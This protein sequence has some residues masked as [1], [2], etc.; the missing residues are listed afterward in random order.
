MRPQGNNANSRGNNQKATTE[1]R[2]FVI[3]PP[4][5]QSSNSVIKVV[6][7]FPDVFPEELSGL[8]P[9]SDIEFAIDLY[10]D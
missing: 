6:R 10:P 1:G 8:P 5:A 7:E 2:A 4:Q 9:K 3:S